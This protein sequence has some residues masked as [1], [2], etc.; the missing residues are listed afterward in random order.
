METW[1][2]FLK[3]DPL[4]KAFT[5]LW[6]C[7]VKV[8]SDNVICLC[9][10]QPR[11]IGR[12]NF[13]AVKASRVWGL[14]F[15]DDLYINAYHVSRICPMTLNAITPCIVK[16]LLL[17][18]LSNKILSS[19]SLSLLDCMVK[20]QNCWKFYTLPSH[21]LNGERGRRKYIWYH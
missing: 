11:V 8:R 20:C 14:I 12:Q 16:C 4:L 17:T 10:I 2:Q 7:N 21:S 3:R 6:K 9:I 13:D 5:V 19:L 15:Y 1:I 18:I